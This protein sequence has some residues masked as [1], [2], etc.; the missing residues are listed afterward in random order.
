MTRFKLKIQGFTSR[1]NFTG[2]YSQGTPTRTFFISGLK[3]RVMKLPF[4]D[5]SDGQTGLLLDSSDHQEGLRSWLETNDRTRAISLDEVLA[6]F[7]TFL[8]KDSSTIFK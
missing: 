6:H 2:P 1:D 5:G 3:S 8:G 7:G 4:F